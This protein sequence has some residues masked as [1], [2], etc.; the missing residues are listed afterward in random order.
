MIDRVA[1]TSVQMSWSDYQAALQHSFVAGMDYQDGVWTERLAGDAGR[2]QADAEAAALHRAAYRIV[3]AAA[4]LDPWPVAQE[5]RRGR[6]EAA[7]R[8]SRATAAPWAR[9]AS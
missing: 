7:G 2:E 5:A 9:E 1:L 8:A 3:Q 6:Q 4:K